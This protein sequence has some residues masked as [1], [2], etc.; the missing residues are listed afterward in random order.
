MA[1]RR[2]GIDARGARS[3]G[4]FRVRILTVE[5]RGWEAGAGN[6]TMSRAGGRCRAWRGCGESER[7]GARRAI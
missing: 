4:W 7:A 3:S 1:D 5:A 2:A 6:A